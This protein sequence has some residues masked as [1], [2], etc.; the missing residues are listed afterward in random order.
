MGIVSAG[1]VMVLPAT[2]FTVLLLPAVGAVAVNA[3]VLLA[4]P[5]LAPMLATLPLM[6]P[7]PQDFVSCSVAVFGVLV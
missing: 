5:V 1:S 4:P 7:A 2:T 3:V 6:A